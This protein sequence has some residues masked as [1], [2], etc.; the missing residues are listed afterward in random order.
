MRNLGLMEVIET[1]QVSVL[2]RGL[3]P[4]GRDNLLCSTARLFYT[5]IF[6][7]FKNK[8]VMYDYSRQVHHNVKVKVKFSIS[9]STRPRKDTG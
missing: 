5:V 8:R 1:L 2:G 9:L 4:V 3:E 7:C 6:K